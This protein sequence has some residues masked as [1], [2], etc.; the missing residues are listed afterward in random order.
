MTFIRTIKNLFIKKN[1]KNR[2]YKTYKKDKTDKTAH[3]QK[4]NCSPAVKN[5]KINEQSCF[6]PE[7]LKSIIDKYNVNHP[8]DKI[9]ETDPKKAWQL[10]KTK[11]S[12]KKEECWL[13]QLDDEAMK[14]KIKKFI[15]APKHPDDWND[16]P[17]EWL[18]NFDIF[19]VAKQY[20]VSYPNFKII[21]PT[22]IDFDTK[23]PEQGGRCVLD[24]LCN[25]SL[26]R[27]IKAKKNK[28][29][30]VFNLDKHDQSGSHWVSLFIDIENKFMFFFDSANNVIP[31]EIW[32]KNKSNKKHDV[33]KMPLVNRI[34]NQGLELNHPIKFAFYNN[35]GITH[36]NGNTEC[37]MYSLFF[38]ITMLTGRTPFTKGYMSVKKRRDLFLKTKITDNVVFGFRKL[39]FND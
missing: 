2:T 19:E 3:F 1:P 36:Q 34:I 24:D 14:E 9:I 26:E 10:L 23:L 11:L 7:I 6:T 27:F 17:D 33:E 12:C 39:Y 18:S 25:F 4:M 30:I 15:F 29:G 16:N 8:D 22:T 35:N 32:S 37:G 20:E 28:I 5:K 38:I 13:N 31:P 21:G